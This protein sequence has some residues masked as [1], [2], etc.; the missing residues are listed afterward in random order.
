MLNKEVVGDSAL[1]EEPVQNKLV[2]LQ[3]TNFCNIN[4]EYCY[5]PDRQSYNLMQQQTVEDIAEALFTSPYVSESLRIVWHAGEPLPVPI[6][7]YRDSIN[8]FNRFNSGNIPISWG[9]QTN[10]TLINQEWCD[11]FKECGIGVGISVDGPEEFH[12]RN[13]VDRKGRGTYKQVMRGLDLL[14]ANGISWGILMVVDR[15]SAQVPEIIWRFFIEN[16]IDSVGFNPEEISGVHNQSSLIHSG[17]LD[18]MVNFYRVLHDLNRKEGNKINIRE[19]D[20]MDSKIKHTQLPVHNGLV[21][22]FEVLSFD[23]VIDLLEGELNIS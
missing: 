13:R 2:I 16:G 3:P 1:T 5:L 21:T 18:D 20:D 4:C 6:S 19:T 17:A 11:L 7:F 9:I 22:P 23:A 8:I 14:R 15:Y 10:G 12:N